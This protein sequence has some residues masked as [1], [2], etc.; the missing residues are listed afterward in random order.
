MFR[1]AV[2]CAIIGAMAVA[3]PQPKA[4]YTAAHGIVYRATAP[5][6]KQYIGQTTTT[7][8]E[9]KRH[10]YGSNQPFTRAIAKYGA[11][12]EWEVL[13]VC[14]SQ[15]SLDAAEIRHITE[16]K[17]AGIVLYNIRE[18]GRGGKH[19]EQTR[20]KMSAARKGK[21]G[22][23]H[24]AEWRANHSAMLKGRKQSPEHIAKRAAA[25]EGN[26]HTPETCAKISAKL[27]GRKES[28]ATREKK[29]AAQM[30][31]KN[32]LGHKQTPEHRANIAAGGKRRWARKR[33]RVTG[34]LV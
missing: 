11:A 28:A 24:T 14:Y 22:K 8:A 34:M 4:D 17:A 13:A 16:A 29:S 10:G 1:F 32:A 2:A 25:R 20:A 6:G 31:N 33:Q 18:G 27:K 7:L 3:V 30:G 26:K 9:R 21:K 12:I 23:P 19:S 5:S 15:L